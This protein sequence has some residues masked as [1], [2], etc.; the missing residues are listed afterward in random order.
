MHKLLAA[1]PGGGSRSRPG[2]SLGQ[3]GD[4]LESV[5]A[6]SPTSV[7]RSCGFLHVINAPSVCTTVQNFVAKM[8]PWECCGALEG[9]SS[10]KIS[11]QPYSDIS[12]KGV[13]APLCLFLSFPF[14]GS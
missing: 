10:E 14:L 1:P 12:G 3:D 13:S 9:K 8:A 7:P 11:L 6:A 5:H 4:G 2:F